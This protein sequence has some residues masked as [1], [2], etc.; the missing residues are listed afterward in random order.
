MHV[1]HFSATPTIHPSV[2]EKK[3][4]AY[5]EKIKQAITKHQAAFDALPER[6]EIVFTNE[7]FRRKLDSFIGYLFGFPLF[8]EEYVTVKTTEASIC[9]EGDDAFMGTS[10]IDPPVWL[11]P[12]EMRLRTVKFP[13]S[14]LSQ[15]VET[16]VLKVLEEA[17]QMR[18]LLINAGYK[19]VD[20]PKA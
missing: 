13:K 16:L 14:L 4:P 10:M 8:R 1:L 2:R 19:D 17:K 12:D 20:R 7:G 5:E 6:F 15:P 18:S 9:Y 3:G 11:P